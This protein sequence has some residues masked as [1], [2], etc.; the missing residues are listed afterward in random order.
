METGGG[1]T[2]SQK[3][4]KKEVNKKNRKQKNQAAVG[5][6]AKTTWRRSHNQ[7]CQMQCKCSASRLGLPLRAFDKAHTQRGH[8][9]VTVGS[10]DRVYHQ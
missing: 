4:M 1:R 7:S 10:E 2:K 5:S 3:E 8:A 6:S 9:R